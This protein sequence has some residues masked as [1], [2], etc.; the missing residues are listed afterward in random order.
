MADN[1]LNLVEIYCSNAPK[2]PQNP[3][4]RLVVATSRYTVKHFATLNDLLT[5]SVAQNRNTPLCLEFWKIVVNL[6]ICWRPLEILIPQTIEYR[7]FTT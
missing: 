7:D 2:W 3:D 4:F 5:H 1:G 6:S